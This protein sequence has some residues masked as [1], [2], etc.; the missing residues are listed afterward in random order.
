MFYHLFQFIYSLL[1]ADPGTL[2]SPTFGSPLGTRRDNLTI[3]NITISES[4]E[5]SLYH[6]GSLLTE[7]DCIEGRKACFECLLKQILL[8]RDA[9]TNVGSAVLTPGEEVFS[10]IFPPHFAFL[11]FIHISV[12]LFYLYLFTV[13]NVR[14]HFTEF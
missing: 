5:R 1:P 4:L 9:P 13:F 7:T 8:V 10:P 3:P 11:L 6:G 2:I 12:P 14:L